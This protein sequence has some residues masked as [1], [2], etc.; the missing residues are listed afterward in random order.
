MRGRQ[1]SGNGSRSSCY[2]A[3]PASG[4]VVT[5]VGSTAG[6]VLLGVHD[7]IN[8]M[9]ALADR[10]VLIAGTNHDEL[11]AYVGTRGVRI[12]G[13][14]G[15]DL[16]HGMGI[17]QQLFGGAGND[18]IY[19]GPGSD[20]IYGGG[21]KDRLVD[22]RGATTVITGPGRAFVDVRDGRGDD[23]V[24]CRPGA[25]PQVRADPGDRVSRAC[26]RATTAESEI[27]G[28]IATRPK[29][30]AADVS[31]DGTNDNPFSEHC[32]PN[33]PG[34]VLPLFPARTLTGLWTNEY[35][36]AYAC[37]YDPIGNTRDA[38]SFLVNINLAPGG[39]ALPDGVGVLGLGPIGMSITRSSTG[40]NAQRF[41]RYSNYAGGTPTGFPVSSATNWTTGSSSYQIQL[42]CTENS[43]QGY[44]YPDLGPKLGTHHRLAHTATALP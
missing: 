41:D 19:G 14:G 12:Y 18:L 6:A 11:G 17:G 38:H 30:H 16:I 35:A 37:P 10:E 40:F 5:L 9:M 8:F 43:A 27:D 36:P 42:H 32:P 1:P 4:S 13:G 23:R 34:C 26:R 31:G 7:R 22:H 3:T 29:A 33:Q 44:R 39:T 2:N 24:I 21:G 25:R 20:T 15:P 28:L